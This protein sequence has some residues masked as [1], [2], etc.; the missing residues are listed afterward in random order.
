M[1]TYVFSIPYKGQHWGTFCF[2]ENNNLVYQISFRD[3]IVF[4]SLT[5]K[6]F[7]SLLAP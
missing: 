4:L 3:K 6:G 1:Y 5:L 7:L 2:S